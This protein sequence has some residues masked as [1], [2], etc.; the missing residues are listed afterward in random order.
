MPA[1]NSQKRESPQA[2]AERE[3]FYE[4]MRTKVASVLNYGGT[5]MLEYD[6]SVLYTAD[7]PVISELL[8]LA[9]EMDAAWETLSEEARRRHKPP[10]WKVMK[11]I[12]PE[13]PAYK[14]KQSVKHK[15]LILSDPAK[16][17]ER[18]PKY[19]SIWENTAQKRLNEHL[20]DPEYSYSESEAA[21]MRSALAERIASA[22]EKA[23]AIL[24]DF[25][26]H[27]VV[28]TNFKHGVFHDVLYYTLKDGKSI[29]THLRE[30]PV[31]N[32]LWYEPD[33]LR[34]SVRSDAKII[35]IV[36]EWELLDK[37]DDEDGSGMIYYTK[38]ETIS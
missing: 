32:V 1:K 29:Q 17:K 20:A 13:M 36:N 22:R 5:K 31:Y 7:R 2:K 28:I 35:R 16:V 23:Q 19:L 4:Q 9:K 34:A 27:E 3:T 30:A 37:R 38:K 21:Q 11:L 12:N 33:P 24:D 8:L 26:N 10:S 6:H 25:Q 14:F 15:Y 18:L